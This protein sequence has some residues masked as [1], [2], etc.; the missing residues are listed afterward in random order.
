MWG[1]S[2]VAVFEGKIAVNFFGGAGGFDVFA[3]AIFE[4]D[5]V[6]AF[7]PELAVMDEDCCFLSFCCHRGN[8]SMNSV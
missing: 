5:T 1:E 4:I 7:E 6:L 2:K 8:D 3:E